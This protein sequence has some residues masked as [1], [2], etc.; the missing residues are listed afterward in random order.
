[1]Y[2]ILYIFLFFFSFY[3]SGVERPRLDQFLVSKN[4]TEDEK[5]VAINYLVKVESKLPL[6]I[7]LKLKGNLKEIRFI[8]VKKQNI[9]SDESIYS[10]ASKRIIFHKSLLNIIKND[11]EERERYKR[12]YLNIEDS[13]IAVALTSFF[14]LYD[15]AP[16][17]EK[18]NYSLIR[19]YRRNCV[20]NKRRKRGCS[21]L[22]KIYAHYFRRNKVTDSLLFKSKI[23]WNAKKK[24]NSKNRRT[25]DLRER[26]S[27]KNFARINFNYFILDRSYKC[28]R[29][30]VYDF[31]RKEFNIKP[32]EDEECNGSKYKVLL[33]GS[34]FIGE[35]YETVL[36]DSSRVY[37]IH[38][39]LAEKGDGVISNFGHSMIRIVLCAPERRGLRGNIIKA[40]P[41]GP[42]CLDDHDYHIVVSYA[43]N[44]DDLEIGLWKGL[45]GKY[46]MILT[47]LSFNDIVE[48]YTVLE[49]R[50]IYSLPLKLSR[51]QINQMI[52]G[53]TE[54][55]W[56]YK[57]SYRYISINCASE[58]YNLIKSVSN[59]VGMHASSKKTPY[60]VL[61]DLIKY[62]FIDEKYTPK[63]KGE[64]EVEDELYFASNFELLFSLYEVIFGETGVKSPRKRKKILTEYLQ[65]SS[66]DKILEDDSWIELK[67]KRMM[68]P[69]VDDNLNSVEVLKIKEKLIEMIS[70][71]SPVQEEVKN[72][73]SNIE[74]LISYLLEL[75]LLFDSPFDISTHKDGMIRYIEVYVLKEVHKISR[76][77]KS[78][79][80]QNKY[81]NL[82]VDPLV[83]LF[84]EI[85]GELKVDNKKKVLIDILISKKINLI[86]KIKKDINYFQKVF[87]S[88]ELN[89]KLWGNQ[90]VKL[91]EELRLI[92]ENIEKL[93]SRIKEILLKND[94]LMFLLLSKNIKRDEVLGIKKKVLKI[95][96]GL[97]VLRRSQ[98]DVSLYDLRKGIGKYL[99]KTPNMAL[100]DDKQLKEIFRNVTLVPQDMIYTGYGIPSEDEFPKREVLIKEVVDRG[101]GMEFVRENILRKFT[102]EKVGEADILA[103]D[104]VR[105]EKFYLL[106]R[107]YLIKIKN[108]IKKRSN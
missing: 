40:T 31:F 4:L 88:G 9:S 49:S 71:M 87:L 5:K 19:G 20:K 100:K 37:Q 92:I 24:K 59:N 70:E 51:K 78:S 72:I 54:S 18:R 12:P 107:R 32:F 42:D 22:G 101:K 86:N 30:S 25:L 77:H 61:G 50:G 43:A 46:P 28:R 55:F 108:I 41:M 99:E 62:N 35:R 102:P 91:E 10:K 23:F 66:K 2:R 39:F 36:L 94:D 60:S 11:R 80:D 45:L 53:I 15:H 57:S 6:K 104:V 81:F 106:H 75:E 97:K 93:K 90:V 83:L 69:L 82:A 63:K 38:Y 79:I 26:S 64:I 3:S 47:L 7:I 48:R 52:N 73:E 29:S 96:A 68:L 67:V 14:D 58:T 103:E 1:M 76:E 56:D 89:R 27:L 74:R 17:E 44:V 85:Y 98:L 21:E 13:L 34:E 33:R 65:S 16:F 8:D 84:E 105:A 95:T